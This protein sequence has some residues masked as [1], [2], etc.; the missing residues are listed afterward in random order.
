[1]Q[2][3]ERA[4]SPAGANDAEI[5]R[6]VVSLRR[7]ARMRVRELIAAGVSEDEIGDY[8]TSVDAALGDP[9]VEQP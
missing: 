7:E 5:E 3:G 4:D 2:A 6:F 1:V 9:E 8:I